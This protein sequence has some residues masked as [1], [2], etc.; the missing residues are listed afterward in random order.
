M[1]R[2]ALV[3][4]LAAAACKGREADALD[5]AVETACACKAHLDELAA[6]N[7]LTAVARVEAKACADDA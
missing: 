4:L 2:L 6:S 7:E 1:R 5:K 3:M